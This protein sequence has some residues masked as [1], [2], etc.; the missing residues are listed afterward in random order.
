MA[1]L[2]TQS[3]SLSDLES[4]IEEGIESS[5]GLRDAQGEVDGYTRIIRIS[6]TS[7]QFEP[8]AFGEQ[9]DDDIY[10]IPNDNLMYRPDNTVDDVSIQDAN[11][12]KIRVQYCYK[13]MV[14]LVN[15]VIGSLNELNNNRTNQR[16]YETMKLPACR[17]QPLLR[18]LSSGTLASYEELCG[19]RA[20]GNE[21]FIISADA[22]IRMQS[23]AINLKIK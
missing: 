16:V 5:G 8:S 7:E 19:D 15:R 10:Q 12:L 2:Y 22:I 4:D 14:P 21:G 17:C 9:N 20:D 23:A 3:A 11:L 6:P 13:L 1:P 18:E